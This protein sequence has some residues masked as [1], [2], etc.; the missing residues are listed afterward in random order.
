MKTTIDPGL[1]NLK[2]KRIEWSFEQES[3]IEQLSK[4]M[5]GLATDQQQVIDLFYLQKKCYKEISEQ[6]GLDWNRV[7]SL[8]QNGRRNLKI[9]MEKHA[10]TKN[11]NE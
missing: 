2:K 4:C 8:I 10:K 3:A 11:E 1:C 6:S 9:C 7:R 5:E